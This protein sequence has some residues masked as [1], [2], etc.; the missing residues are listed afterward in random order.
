M[1]FAALLLLALPLVAQVTPAPQEPDTVVGIGVG[2]QGLGPAQIQG[3]WFVAHHAGTGLYLIQDTDFVRMSGGKVGTSARAGVLTIIRRV[4]PLW[5]GLVGDA[6]VAEGQ[7]GSA[8]G[9][10]SGWGLAGVRLFKWPVDVIAAAQTVKVAGTGEVGQY[11][12]IFS[13]SFYK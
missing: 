13:W 10:L 3:G 5:I 8:T 7:T 2:V 1:K 9:A 6:G 11:R 4:G 12:L